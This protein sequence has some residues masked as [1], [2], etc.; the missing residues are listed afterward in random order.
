MDGHTRQVVYRAEQGV[1]LEL[2]GKKGF[3]T[4]W[5][6]ADDERLSENMR[7]L[8]VAVTRARNLLWLGVPANALEEL[9]PALLA[10]GFQEAGA[11]VPA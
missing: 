7:L 10:C 6:R 4:A 8:Y 3:E 2:A 1:S 9:R 5:A 11:A